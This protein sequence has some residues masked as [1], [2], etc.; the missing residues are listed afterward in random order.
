MAPEA[1]DTRQ[2]PEALADD[3]PYERL[4]ERLEQVVG[5]LERADLPLEESVHAFKEGMDLLKRAEEKLRA[6]EKK[7]EELLENGKTVPLTADRGMGEPPAPATR[8]LAPAA[9]D[10]IPF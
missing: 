2:S 8:K 10:D 9:D 1:R 4:V 5:R 3:A 7:V 6:A